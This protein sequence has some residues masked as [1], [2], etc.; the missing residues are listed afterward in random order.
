MRHVVESVE[1]T[2][3]HLERQAIARAL[4]DL[5]LVPYDDPAA[6][7]G[8]ALELA[9]RADALGQLELVHRARLVHADVIGRQGDT[10]GAGTIARQVNEWAAEKDDAHL[11]ARS[12]RLLSAFYSRIGDMSSALEHAVRAVELLTPDTRPRLVA[13]HL[14]GLALA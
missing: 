1:G 2:E 7:A 5:E 10:A 3:E 12:E 6:A 13:D 11:L 4:D 8:P 9:Q 14:M